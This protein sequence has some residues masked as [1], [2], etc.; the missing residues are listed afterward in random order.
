[1]DRRAR[2]GWPTRDASKP[3]HTRDRGRAMGK[4]L[5]YLRSAPHAARACRSASSAGASARAQCQ[6]RRA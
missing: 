5:A 6:A 2:S 1:M 3:S 4:T